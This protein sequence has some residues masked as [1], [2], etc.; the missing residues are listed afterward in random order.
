MTNIT[1]NTDDSRDQR[2]ASTSQHSDESCDQ[3]G[4]SGS[5]NSDES[6]DQHGASDSPRPSSAMTS[7]AQS[8]MGIGTLCSYLVGGRGAIITM[9]QSRWSLAIGGMF[10]LVGGLARH[11]D[12]ADLLHQPWFLLRPLAASLVVSASIFLVVHLVAWFKL[13]GEPGRP[14][15][16]R[17]YQSFLGLFWMTAPMALIYAVPYERFLSEEGALGANIASLALVSVWRVTLMARVISVM[18]GFGFLGALMLVMIVADTAAIVALMNAPLPT[19]D[20]MGGLQRTR[21]EAIIATTAFNVGIGAVL[22][23][24]I[25]VMGVLVTLARS[26]PNWPAIDGTAHDLGNDGT[27]LDVGN[28]SRR[29]ETRARAGR[30]TLALIALP[31]VLVIACVPIMMVT[32]PE[33][34]RAH[35]VAQMLRSGAIDDALAEMSRH[36]RD[37]FPPIWSPPPRP[38]FREWEP[39]IEQVL[40]AI[41]RKPPAPWVASTFAEKARSGFGRR[42]MLELNRIGATEGGEAIAPRELMN[43]RDSERTVLKW[44]IEIDPSYTEDQRERLRRAIARSEEALDAP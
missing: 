44:L 32:Q 22:S 20:L 10:V 6:C 43:T 19:V 25:W 28:G 4:A 40:E 8:T 18:Y 5:Q 29:A 7:I 39:P 21:S 12:G 27:A 9:A 34:I 3:H 41:A 36:Q 13:R 42:F 15:L 1:G 11:Y 16:V 35:R 37:D 17:A 33:Q 23:L 24:A 31:I 30:P 26:R 2:G 14:S 38:A